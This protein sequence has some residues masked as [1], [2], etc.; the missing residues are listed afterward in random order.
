MTGS[1]EGAAPIFHLATPEAWAAARASGEI[2]PP[3]LEAEGFVH[4]STE[5]QVPGTIDR[6][7]S[8]VDDLVL[9]QVDPTSVAHDLRWEEGRPGEHFPHVYRAIALDEVLDVVPW[10]R[11]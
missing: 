9:L 5:D 11:S 6:H 10:H 8:A 1:V 7:F 3:S 4:C 2:A